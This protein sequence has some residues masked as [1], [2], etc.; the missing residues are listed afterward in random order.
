MAYIDRFL[1]SCL[2][3]VSVQKRQTGKYKTL[4]ARRLNQRELHAYQYLT[5]S[6]NTNARQRPRQ[7]EVVL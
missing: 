4:R 5:R 6:F 2:Q 1:A 7:L 3:A